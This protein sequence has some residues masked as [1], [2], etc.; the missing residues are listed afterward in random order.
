MKLACAS[1]AFDRAIGSGELTQL[2]F[3]E[4]CAHQLTCDGIVLD[5]RHFPRN[6]NDYLA[7]VKKLA[8]DW[9]LSIA[10]VTD[11]RFFS[12]SA[13]AMEGALHRAQMLGAPLIAAPLGRV[14]DGSWSDQLERLNVATSMAKA[15]NITL[16]VRNAIDTFAAGTH[17]Y[18]RVA[19]ETDSAW[20]R[21]GPEPDA[22]EGGSDVAALRANTVLLW[23]DVATQTERSIAD[24]NAAFGDF[25]GFLSLDHRDGS[26]EQAHMIR[27]VRRWRN[28][29]A[30]SHPE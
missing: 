4:L 25:V 17:D 29:L 22:L 6:D 20:L 24:I 13:D 14:V 19:K 8:T 9:G 30:H 1:T 5:V 3:L 21:Y 10:A 16:A 7:Q 11:S 15:R 2:E 27:A 28:V 23:T 12:E 18:R 26:A